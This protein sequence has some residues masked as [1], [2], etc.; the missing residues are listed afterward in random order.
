LQA[1]IQES[2]IATMGA[3]HAFGKTLREPVPSAL[4]NEMII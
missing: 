4:R 2:W 3:R 1:K